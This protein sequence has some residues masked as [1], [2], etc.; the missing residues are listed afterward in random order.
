[1]EETDLYKEDRIGLKTLNEQK[2][3]TL[4]EIKDADHLRFTEEW[5]TENIVDKYLRG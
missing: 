3:I 4:I 2:K 5:F 1:M